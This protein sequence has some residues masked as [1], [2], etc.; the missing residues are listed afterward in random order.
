MTECNPVLTPVDTS[1]K[2]DSKSGQVFDD[3]IL[4]HSYVG[5]LQYFTFTKPDISYEINKCVCTCMHPRLITL[6]LSSLFFITL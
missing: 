3:P 5:D 6:M 4:I 1:S 2:T